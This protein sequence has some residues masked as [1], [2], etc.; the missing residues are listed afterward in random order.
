M[1]IQFFKIANHPYFDPIVIGIIV[2]NIFT[3]M[4]QMDDSVP[5]LSTVLT[6]MN[7]GFSCIFILEMVIKLF[8][9]DKHYFLSGWN[10]F[11]FSVV[12]ASI[13]DIILTYAQG[14]TSTPALSVLPQIARIFR[15]L[16]VTKLLRLFKSFKGL[17]KLIETFIYMMPAFANGLA[18]L[19]LYLFIM[20]IISCFLMSDIGHD[21]SGYFSRQNNF[22]NFHS[23]LQTLYITMTGENW[24]IYM[25]ES[26]QPGY[27]DC[28]NPDCTQPVN[29]LFWLVFI[30]CGQKIFLEMLG[31][32]VLDQFDYNYIR[33]NNP[34]GV[35]ALLESDF[36]DNWILAT[37]KYKAEKLESKQLVD[38]VLKLRQPLG[39]SLNE[40]Q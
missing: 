28:I 17:Q 36:R 35:F 19:L 26:T 13:L 1:L 3:M 12:M 25:F 11:D 39:M 32:I 5:M 4:V 21:S 27:V 33:E 2:L 38:F 31:L 16:R 14:V 24:Y 37:T 7:L 29:F 20:S 22:N 23:A 9:Y 34:L 40:L 8:A 30:F 18:L 6:Y 15:V 10:I